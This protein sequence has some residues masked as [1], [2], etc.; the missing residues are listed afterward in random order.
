MEMWRRKVESKG[1]EETK[2]SNIKEVSQ[3]DVKNNSVVNKNNNHY[4]GKHDEN[5]EEEVSDGG[6]AKVE[7]L[8]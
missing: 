6:G 5:I 3:E 4:N 2:I 1:E 7:C 8:F